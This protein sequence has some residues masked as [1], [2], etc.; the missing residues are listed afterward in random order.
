MAIYMWR[1]YQ[2]MPWANT[3]AYRPLNS[4]TTVNDTSWNNNNLTK[5]GNVGFQVYADACNVDCAY[6]PWTL[7]YTTFPA[8]NTILFW[9]FVPTTTTG[10][11][12]PVAQIGWNVIQFNS[13]NKQIRYRYVNYSW[14]TGTWDWFNCDIHGKRVLMW[15][16]RDTTVPNITFFIKGSW[17]DSTETYTSYPI[18][19]AYTLTFS[20]GSYNTY[21]SAALAED[22][23]RTAQEV[24]DYYNRT[25]WLY[26]I[27]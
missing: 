23:T 15:Y 6:A 4:T 24:T 1:E 14:W 21:L 16:T 9:S 17:I 18:I 26:W 11:I 12:I 7:T 20:N 27:N 22:K 8:S 25:K 5:S 3:L 13:S 19:N 10:T 2:W